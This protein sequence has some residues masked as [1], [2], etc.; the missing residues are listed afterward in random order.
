MERVERVER[1]AEPRRSA[2]SLGRRVSKELVESMDDAEFVENPES[3][4]VP[5]P[6]SMDDPTSALSSR[7]KFLRN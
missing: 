1:V 7:C 5:A 3:I 6:E 2:T 4:D